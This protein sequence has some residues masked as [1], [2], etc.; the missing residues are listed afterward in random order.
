MERP[1]REEACLRNIPWILDND[2][3]HHGLRT[4][5]NWHEF[6]MTMKT[7]DLFFAR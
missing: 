6:E 1:V 5:N 2:V 4:E 3:I 7:L